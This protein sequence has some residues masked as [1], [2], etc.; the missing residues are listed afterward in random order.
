MKGN[1]GFVPSNYVMKLKVSDKYFS[2]VNLPF[3]V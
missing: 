3:L 1:I 2:K